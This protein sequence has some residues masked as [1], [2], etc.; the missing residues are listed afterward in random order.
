[1]KLRNK[2]YI[3]IIFLLLI[4]S[5]LLNTCGSEPRIV[6]QELDVKELVCEDGLKVFEGRV[7][8]LN[9]IKS[10]TVNIQ[11]H[12]ATIVF[13]ESKLSAEKLQDHLLGFG[14]TVN[15]EQGNAVS[16]KRLP[17]CCRQ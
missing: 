12:K 1:M 15:G 13:Q 10:V 6:T 16:R 9:G 8:E 17:A 14:F 2:H 7:L 11:A 3:I 5:V 4:G